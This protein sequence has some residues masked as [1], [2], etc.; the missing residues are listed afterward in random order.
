[1]VQEGHA[2]KEIAKVFSVAVHRVRDIKRGRSWVR[3]TGAPDTSHKIAM[4]AREYIAAHM[5][6]SASSECIE[7]TGGKDRRGYGI[8]D[9]KG[10]SIRAHRLA[11]AAYVGPIPEGLFVMHKCDNPSCIN[12]QH[13]MTGTHEDNMR[14]M[15]EKGRKPVGESV[16]TS[17]LTTADVVQI[18]ELMESGYGHLKTA[19]LFGV[20]IACVSRIRNGTAWKHVPRPAR[21]VT[22][23]DGP[24]RAY[25][26]L[27]CAAPT[28]TDKEKK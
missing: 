7:W 17:K 25:A 26:H 4:N 18:I 20:G 11:Y 12:P 14:D 21:K 3:V 5:R 23:D 9:F 6:Q 27:E 16:V 10:K 15:M 19:K 13:L 24:P 1:M 8:A 2:S 28:Y 22:G